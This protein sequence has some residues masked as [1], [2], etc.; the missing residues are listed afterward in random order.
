MINTA[1]LL[2]RLTREPDMRTTQ[3]GTPVASFTLAVDRGRRDENG[4]TQADFIPCVAWQKTAETIGRYVTKGQLIAV[5][6]RIQTRRY[7]DRE[8]FDR[9]MTEVIV[10]EF[11]F[12][13]PR[14]N[15]IGA[16]PTPAP[17]P[18]YQQPAYGTTGTPPMQPA[19][20][21]AQRP[22]AVQTTLEP[23]QPRYMS[24]R[25]PADEPAQQPVYQQPAYGTVNIATTQQTQPVAVP[26]WGFEELAGIGDDDLPF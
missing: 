21:V 19:Q 24:Q 25:A 10:D 9:T 17:Q 2:G 11:S 8:G 7:K 5:R 13:E 16:S 4:Q 26:A 18:A 14:N 23:E 3:S 20:T 15:T 1:I 6:G 22:V 12:A